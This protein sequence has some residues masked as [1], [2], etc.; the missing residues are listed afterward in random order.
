MATRTLLI[1]SSVLLVSAAGGVESGKE[2]K[3]AKRTLTA[4]FTAKDLKGVRQGT[5][6]KHLSITSSYQFFSQADQLKS[7]HEFKISSYKTN[8]MQTI[9]LTEDVVLLTFQA[10]IDSTFRGSKMPSK[11]QVVETWVKR[12][13]KWLQASYQQTPLAISRD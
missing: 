12:D 6:A 3:Q 1:V 2:V 8:R 5:T 4:A 9:P 7:L 10:D 13:G 11:V